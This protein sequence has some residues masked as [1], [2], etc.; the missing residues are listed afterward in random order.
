MKT[1]EGSRYIFNLA[2]LD[3]NYII[4]VA[5][6]HNESG[7]SKINGKDIKEVTELTEY[8]GS[9][10]CFELP[11]MINYFLAEK[12][13]VIECRRDGKQSLYQILDSLRNKGQLT[14]GQVSV[15]IGS[16]S[17]LFNNVFYVKS[18]NQYIIN[19]DYKFY[20]V[21]QQQTELTSLNNV[22]FDVDE[23]F[24]STIAQHPSEAIIAQLQI[25]YRQFIVTEGLSIFTEKEPS[26]TFPSEQQI[27][28][29]F[30]QQRLHLVPSEDDD[31]DEE[32]IPD[33]SA[34][35]SSQAGMFG[36]TLNRA[37]NIAK[38][39]PELEETEDE[40]E[41]VFREFDTHEDFLAFKA[42]S[43]AGNSSSST[44]AGSNPNTLFGSK[45]ENKGWK[46]GVS[47][48]PTQEMIDHYAAQ[49][50]GRGYMT[51]P[52]DDISFTFK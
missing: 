24:Y 5:N 28:D 16:E 10:S 13:L 18:L 26:F 32:V 14:G 48:E 29:F 41:R 35:T 36:Q 38:M 23:G 27:T 20:V 34:A 39:A 11:N 17:K 33:T 51:F 30:N 4:S 22:A 47:I 21:N 15:S 8:T 50:T 1:A 45:P 40:T 44:S 52:V 6:Y 3:L 46:W 9:L 37:N 19:D 2:T 42:A 25:M 43:D 7:I 49:E 12:E 31:N